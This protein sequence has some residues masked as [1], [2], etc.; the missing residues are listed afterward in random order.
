MSGFLSIRIAESKNKKTNF[1]E[2][3]T[4]LESDFGRKRIDGKVM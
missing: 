3:D 4:V 1:I 2:I